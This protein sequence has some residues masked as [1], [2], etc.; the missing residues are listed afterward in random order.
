MS[1]GMRSG[2]NWM[3]WNAEVERLGERRDQQRLG[4]AGHA[5]EQAVTA[6]EQRDQQLLDDLLLADDPLLDLA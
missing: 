4:E 2:V 5:D 3:R 1:A 6:R